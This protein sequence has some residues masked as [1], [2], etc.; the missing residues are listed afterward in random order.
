LDPTGTVALLS[1]LLRGIPKLPGAMCRNHRELFDSADPD[2][3]AAA[4]EIC[5]SCPSLDACRTWASQQCRLFGVVAG[6][7][8]HHPSDRPTKRNGR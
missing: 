4:V 6:T 5:R 7:V 3:T 2:D 1:K 8:H